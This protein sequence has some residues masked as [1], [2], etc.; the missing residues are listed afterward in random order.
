MHDAIPPILARRDVAQNKFFTTVAED[1]AT[2][3][4]SYTYS[5]IDATWDAVL[6]IPVLANG[7][8]VI[9]RIYRHPYR[10]Y[11]HEFP[12]G[13]IEHG[14]DPCVAAARELEEETGY[15]AK[16]CALIHVVEPVPGLCRMRLHIVLAT[17]LQQT[18][19]REHETLELID[20]VELTLAE[21]NKLMEQKPCSGFLSLGLLLFDKMQH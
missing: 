8:L 10:A 20:V 4:G 17:D 6:V 9:E 19:K 18:G 2:P 15:R 1:L 3:Q 13:G 11:L 7:R 12:A 14:E 16:N 21:A 5:F